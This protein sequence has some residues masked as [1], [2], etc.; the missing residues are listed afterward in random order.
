MIWKIVLSSAIAR[1][2]KKNLS[3][4]NQLIQLKVQ[5]TEKNLKKRL[6]SSI[7]STI[8]TQLA[9]FLFSSAVFQQPKPQLRE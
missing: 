2:M 1:L 6:K 5:L 9:K 8:S 4:T 7:S 3:T